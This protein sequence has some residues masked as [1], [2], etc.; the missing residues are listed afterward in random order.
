MNEVEVWFGLM[1]HGNFY[2]GGNDDEEPMVVIHSV[3]E[4]LKLHPDDAD[5]IM[6]SSGYDSY[7]IPSLFKGTIA[8]S[9]DYFKTLTGETK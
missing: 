2:V 5:R 3:D 8:F 9:Q 7:V 6:E 1:T 4:R